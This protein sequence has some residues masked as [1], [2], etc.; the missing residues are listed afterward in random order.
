MAAAQLGAR[1]HPGRRRLGS[2]EDPPSQNV[3]PV[4]VWP[5]DP[6][7]RPTP[8]PDGPRQCLQSL[9]PGGTGPERGGPG[10]PSAARTS[11]ADAGA[12]DRASPSPGGHA[13]LVSGGPRAMAAGGHRTRGP[14]LSRSSPPSNRASVHDSSHRFVHPGRTPTEQGGDARPRPRSACGRRTGHVPRHLRLSP[15]SPPPA[16]GTSRASHHRRDPFPI[17]P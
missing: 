16:I 11:G 6:G 2:R 1:H 9:Q 3:A 5:L 7:L 10:N 4:A 17:S 15:P 14:A 13:F 8:P 12:A